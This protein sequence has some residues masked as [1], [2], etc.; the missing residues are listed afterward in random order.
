MKQSDIKMASKLND[1]IETMEK[2][3]ESLTAEKV[4]QDVRINL[5]AYHNN[6][7]DRTSWLSSGIR[8]SIRSLIVAD[9]QA[10]VQF[11]KKRIENL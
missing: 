2:V 5:A 1:K 3:L 6:Y 10:Q 9:L 4:D 8:D 11:M 7:N